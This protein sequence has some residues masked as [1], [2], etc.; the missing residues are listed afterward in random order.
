MDDLG[1]KHGYLQPNVK[2]LS[3][4]IKDKLKRG[5]CYLKEQRK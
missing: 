4:I 1:K 3:L 2:N 5:K